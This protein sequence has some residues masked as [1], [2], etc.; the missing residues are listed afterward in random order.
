MMSSTVNTRAIQN[1]IAWLEESRAQREDQAGAESLGTLTMARAIIEGNGGRIDRG[2][3]F[4]DD[5]THAAIERVAAQ[6]V[7]LA[8]PQGEPDHRARMLF[9]D[10]PP[11]WWPQFGARPGES[12]MI[13]VLQTLA[14]T[15]VV[16]W[17]KVA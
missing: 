3:A 5:G 4:R 2:M 17:R 13:D 7:G 11:P 1:A 6:T 10:V 9:Q 14:E 15:D 12:D 16:A 8:D